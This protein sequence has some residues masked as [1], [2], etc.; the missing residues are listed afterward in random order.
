MVKEKLSKKEEELISEQLKQFI[1]PKS[2]PD[3]IR[4]AILNNKWIPKKYQIY[5]PKGD[6]DDKEHFII[7]ENAIK[8]FENND[9]TDLD[10]LALERILSVPKIVNRIDYEFRGLVTRVKNSMIDGIDKL[11]EEDAKIRLHQKTDTLNFSGNDRKPMKAGSAPIIHVGKDSK[12]DENDNLTQTDEKQATIGRQEQATESRQITEEKNDN[13]NKESYT[14]N[15]TV[16]RKNAGN[17]T[18]NS[19]DGI[20]FGEEDY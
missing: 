14:S 5:I 1:R 10:K 6:I 18:E 11:P 8:A 13:T 16:R 20:D 9:M 3:I 2:L 4:K 19:T 12:F 15:I 17:S 7:A